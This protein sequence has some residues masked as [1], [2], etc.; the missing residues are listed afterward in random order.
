[1]CKVN[2]LQTIK[3]QKKTKFDLPLSDMYIFMQ[4]I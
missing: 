1:M 3:K 4:K 2:Q